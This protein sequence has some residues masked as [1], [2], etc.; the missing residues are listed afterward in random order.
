M[1]SDYED[2]GRYRVSEH[3]P[4]DTLC[5]IAEAMKKAEEREEGLGEAVS[6]ILSEDRCMLENI[7]DYIDEHYQGVHESKLHYIENFLEETGYFLEI[8]DK[9]QR[10]QIESYFDYD[11]FVRDMELNSE[12]FFIE[13]AWNKYHAFRE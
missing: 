12:V 6:E 10:E 1:I 13:T 9:R 3:E 2:F 7:D 11:A 8:E 4:I 5:A